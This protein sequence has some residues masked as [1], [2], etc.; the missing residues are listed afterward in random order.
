MADN[1]R[2]AY[3]TNRNLQDTF[4]NRRPNIHYLILQPV[5]LELWAFSTGNNNLLHLFQCWMQSNLFL[6]WDVILAR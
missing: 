1:D 5:R 2:K 3:N 4:T 6:K